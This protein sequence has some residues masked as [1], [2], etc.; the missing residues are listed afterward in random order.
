MGLGP[1]WD[2]SGTTQAVVV[3]GLLWTPYGP[4]MDLGLREKGELFKDKIKHGQHMF[5]AACLEI[6]KLGW[7]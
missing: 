3:V 1:D 6:K 7:G 5:V 4:P 2:S